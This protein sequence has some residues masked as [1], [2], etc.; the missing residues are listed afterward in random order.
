MVRR[1]AR[2]FRK[3]P[4][5]YVKAVPRR[6][7]FP[8]RRRNS[9]KYNTHSFKR[10]DEIYTTGTKTI[11]CNFGAS[12]Y[13]TD[14]RSFTLSDVTDYSEFTNLYDKYMITGVKVYFDYSMSATPG[15]NTTSLYY[16]K[17]FV[18]IDK[19]DSAVPTLNEMTSS[20][21]VKV[22]RFNATNNTRSIYL[23]PS[24][25]TNIYNGM[26]FD[27]HGSNGKR[28]LDCNNASVPHYGMKLLAQGVPDANLGSIGMRFVYYLRFRGVE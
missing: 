27:A 8:R 23:R 10:M 13:T 20:T 28:W 22:L 19:D 4:K 3:N 5:K 12:G 14:S 18:K 17:L 2:K 11:S 24:C 16:P 7:Y 1:F 15:G 21:Q 9:Y 26:L 6:R 25:L